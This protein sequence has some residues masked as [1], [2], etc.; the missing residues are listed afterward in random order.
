MDAQ[1]S[2]YRRLL[3]PRRLAEATAGG[4]EVLLL[5]ALAER[6]VHGLGNERAG[7]ARKLRGA[8]F[9]LLCGVGSGEAE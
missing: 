1:R 4:S 8:E 7:G 3:F 6:R 9:L 5:D 2:S